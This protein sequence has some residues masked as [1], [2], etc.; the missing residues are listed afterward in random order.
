MSAIRV[1][2]GYTGRTK[3]IKF[4]GCYHGHVDSLLVA[5]GSAAATLSVPDSPGVTPG[6][7]AD[8]IVLNY[9]NVADL[10]SAFDKFGDQ[11]AAVILDRSLA[12]WEP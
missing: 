9:N 5:A 7:S 11:I 2:R 6:T 3:I 1:A 10:E 8:T 4:A 12:I